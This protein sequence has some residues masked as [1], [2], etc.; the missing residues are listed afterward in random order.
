[1]SSDN[2]EDPTIDSFLGINRPPPKI[3]T[4]GIFILL[5][6]A[7]VEKL[8]A[9]FIFLRKVSQC[10]GLSLDAR[11]KRVANDAVGFVEFSDLCRI[12]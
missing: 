3:K 7:P 12:C 11:E 2:Q 10:L 6:S 1:M 4:K 5:G 9:V 8:F